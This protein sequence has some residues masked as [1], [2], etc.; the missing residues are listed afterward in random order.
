MANAKGQIMD[1]TNRGKL[2]E[3]ILLKHLQLLSKNAECIHMRIPDAHGGALAPKPGDF[4]HM[5]AGELFLIECKSVMHEYRLPYKNVDPGQVARL[6]R[7]AL[8]GAKSYIMIYHA[9]VDKWR[10]RPADHFVERPFSSW[11]FRVGR[12]IPTTLVDTFT[13]MYDHNNNSK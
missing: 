2:A 9:N 4:L 1:T 10:V 8:A 12:D 5:K 13:R 3:D 11:D 7:W 6:R